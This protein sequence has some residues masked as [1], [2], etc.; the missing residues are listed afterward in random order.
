MNTGKIQK[1]LMEEIDSLRNG[2]STT[3]RAN[4]VA[5]LAA[6]YVYT[7]RVEIENKREEIKIGNLFGQIRWNNIDGLEVNIPMITTENRDGK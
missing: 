7:V 6:Q 3:D 5:K 2:E 1:I 4:S